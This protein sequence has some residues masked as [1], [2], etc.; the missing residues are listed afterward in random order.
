MYIVLEI[1]ILYMFEYLLPTYII[2]KIRLIFKSC[3][4]HS[5]GSH[6]AH[7]ILVFVAM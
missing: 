7:M 4:S 5:A 1:N 3:S 6:S 2:K